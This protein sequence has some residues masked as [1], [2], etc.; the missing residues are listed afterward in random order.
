MDLT[1]A[2]AATTC[3]HAGAPTADAVRREPYGYDTDLEEKADKV[4]PIIQL[5]MYH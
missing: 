4:R 2:H 1:C 3:V 5:C